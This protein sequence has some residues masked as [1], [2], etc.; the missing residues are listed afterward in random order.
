MRWVK[1]H[2]FLKINSNKNY[3]FNC[4]VGYTQWFTFDLP[5]IK[6]ENIKS[7][8]M[9]IS[10]NHDII[11]GILT[12]LNLHFLLWHPCKFILLSCVAINRK[13][14]SVFSY[15]S[16]PAFVGTKFSILI[17][18]CLKCLHGF[19]FTDWM[20][21]SKVFLKQYFVLFWCNFLV[22]EITVFDHIWSNFISLNHLK[23]YYSFLCQKFHFQNF[24][25]TGLK[26][27]EHKLL[28]PS[29]IIL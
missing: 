23:L 28:L 14:G 27:R 9:L 8:I 1:Q 6:G 19:C 10:D 11:L 13:P 5:L 24:R 20:L 16:S 29:E 25:L 22:Q 4:Y 21:I 3:A 17:H 26:K 15:F 7:L 12:W 18:F 2:I